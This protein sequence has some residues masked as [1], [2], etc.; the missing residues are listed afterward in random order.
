V[1]ESCSHPSR[2]RTDPG[3]F[4]LLVLS[5]IVVALALTYALASLLIYG[6]LPHHHH[7]AFPLLGI[8]P[9]GVVT[10]MPTFADLR[11]VT[12]HSECGV[13]L[14]DLASGLSAGCDPF[15]RKSSSLSY[16][17]MSILA[18]RFLAV[19]GHHTGLLGFCFGLAVITILALLSR[20]LVKPEWFAN[21]LLAVILLGF[22]MQLALE[23]ANI[24]SVIFLL[25]AGLAAVSCLAARWA[26]LP[27]AGLAWLAVAIKMYPFVGLTAWCL[28]CWRDWRRRP[29]VALAVLA[30]TG[31]G[32]AHVLPWYRQS[33]GS[34]AQPLKRD[35][36]HGL[37][38]PQMPWRVTLPWGPSDHGPLQIPFQPVLAITLVLLALLLWRR[39]GLHRCWLKLLQTRAAGFERDCLTAL[40]SLLA[41][42][43]LGCYL[44]SGSYDY[45]LILALPAVIGCGALLTAEPGLK[46]PARA[47]L[48]FLLLGVIYGWF[49]PLFPPAS[50]PFR[51]NLVCDLV[52]MPLLAGTLLAM[53]GAPL[54][55]IQRE[56]ASPPTA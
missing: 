6:F 32:V 26:A 51:L 20:R 15:D 11:W 39:L 55:G 9:H 50:L 27:A 8:F 49:A 19:K 17:P 5:R 23:R 41:L 48:A 53:V 12:A 16:P 28:G 1:A 29:W 35:I 31:A 52:F 21:G 2:L 36:G 18:A 46:P 42:V 4:A 22:P 13:R 54:T 40:P 33:G 45:R 30:G 37:I 25:L 56:G 43:W 34:A 47:A 38:V 44:L 7:Q 24:D 10:R 14:S 3:R